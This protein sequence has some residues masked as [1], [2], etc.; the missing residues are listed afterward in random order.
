MNSRAVF[1]LQTLSV[2]ALSAVSHD[3]DVGPALDVAESAAV[4]LAGCLSDDTPAEQER[5][6]VHLVGGWLDHRTHAVDVPGIVKRAIAA[7]EALAA[8]MVE[9]QKP[10]P[11][12]EPAPTQAAASPA[13]QP[14]APAAPPPPPAPAAPAAAAST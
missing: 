7:S 14:A 2:M 10:E 6:I 11:A 9:A 3:L 12:K 5:V 4:E 8:R 13:Q 1:F